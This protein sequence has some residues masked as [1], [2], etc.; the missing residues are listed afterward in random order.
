MINNRLSLTNRHYTGLYFIRNPDTKIN[1]GNK[2]KY[3]IE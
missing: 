2:I 3:G 1:M